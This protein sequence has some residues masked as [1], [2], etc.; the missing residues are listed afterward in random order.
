MFG[1]FPRED[2]DLVGIAGI[3][4]GEEGSV[5]LCELLRLSFD[6]RERHWGDCFLNNE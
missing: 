4:G 2:R 1:D 6:F 3:G 5:Y